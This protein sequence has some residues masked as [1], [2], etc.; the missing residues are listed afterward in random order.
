MRCIVWKLI[1]LLGD[2][3]P[4][5]R[6]RKS[7][8]Y[9]I[10]IL[11]FLLSI[12]SSTLWDR[13]SQSDTG[14]CEHQVSVCDFLWDTESPKVTLAFMNTTGADPG[15]V[16]REGRDPKG[17]PGGWYNPKIEQK[18]PKISWI[19][20]IYLSKGGQCRFGPYVDPP[21]HQ[22]SVCDFLWD[23]ESPKVTLAFVNTRCQ[24]VTFSE[25]QKAP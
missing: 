8:M 22:V 11:V 23:T 10:S 1:T 5:D 13:K 17:G 3:S 2:W 18:L 20:M 6:Q 12:L 25:T 24:F 7:R 16:K 19:C 21:L 14:V 15:Y 4:W 9:S